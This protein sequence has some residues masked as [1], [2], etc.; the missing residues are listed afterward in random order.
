L[1]RFGQIVNPLLCGLRDAALRA[2]LTPATGKPHADVLPALEIL[3]I[4]TLVIKGRCDYLSWSPTQEYLNMLPD[5]KL[6]YLNDSGHNAYQDE[7][8]RY[9]ADVRAFRQRSA[10]QERP[11][12]G[13]HVP[14]DYEGQ[15]RIE[16]EQSQR[17]EL[18]SF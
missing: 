17:W 11:H 15:P 7:P 4:P 14:R 1:G 16:L 9:M 10:E 3:G 13:Q 12:D 6:L 18:T 2:T 8:E 5:A